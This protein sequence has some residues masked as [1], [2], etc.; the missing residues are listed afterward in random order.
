MVYNR[1]VFQQEVQGIP[2]VPAVFSVGT[3]DSPGY[4]VETGAHMFF[5]SK[6]NVLLG[7]QYRGAKIRHIADATTGFPFRAP[8]GDPYVLDLSGLGAKF[9][10]GFGL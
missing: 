9:A 4:Y 8:N 2:G 5:A 6:F 7:V 1:V 10:V 3:A